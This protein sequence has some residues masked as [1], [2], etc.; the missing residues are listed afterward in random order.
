MMAEACEELAGEMHT[1]TAFRWKIDSLASGR[2]SIFLDAD[3]YSNDDTPDYFDKWPQSHDIHQDH[4]F[5]PSSSY[6]EPSTRFEPPRSTPSFLSF[7]SCSAWSLTG[8]SRTG[9]PT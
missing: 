3:M 7:H 9:F 4:N 2:L 6:Y 1:E 5:V 8:C